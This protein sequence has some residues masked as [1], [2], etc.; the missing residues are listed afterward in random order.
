VPLGQP[1]VVENRGRAGIEP[2]PL[3]S[4][5]FDALIK[6]EIAANIVLVKAAGLTF[7]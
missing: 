3:T 2:M 7:N 1:I 4:A 5:E 6:T